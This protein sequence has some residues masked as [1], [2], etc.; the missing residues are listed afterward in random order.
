MPISK[1]KT[2]V[3]SVVP[4]TLRD[5]IKEIAESDQ[6]SISSLIAFVLQDY[7]RKRKRAK[8]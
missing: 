6:R 5:D 8:K 3:V 4:K 1:D 2:K 7:V